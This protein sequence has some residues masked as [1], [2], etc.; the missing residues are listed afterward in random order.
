MLVS[1]IAC[2]L[3]SFISGTSLTQYS[4]REHI[5]Q[6]QLICSPYEKGASMP[7]SEID[8]VL[9]T[10]IRTTA[11]KETESLLQELLIVFAGPIIRSN[12]R[13]HLGFYVSEDGKSANCADALDLNFEIVAKITKRLNLL[14]EH[15]RDG[16]I[17]DYGLYVSRVARNCCADYLREKYPLRHLLNIRIL[18]ILSNSGRYKS[19]RGVNYTKLVEEPLRKR[20]QK[21]AED[22]GEKP[23]N[24]EPPAQDRTPQLSN[25]EIVE[26]VKTLFQQRASNVHKQPGEL[27]SWIIDE[28]FDRYKV[29]LPTATLVSLII[30]IIGFRER[31]IES[32]DTDVPTTAA[33]LQDRAPRADQV[34]ETR[35]SFQF[36][37]SELTKLP[38]LERRIMLLSAVDRE[39]GDLISI[40]LES[41][42]IR[43]SQLLNA[44]EFSR[45]ELLSLWQKIPM[46]VPNLAAC[47]DISKMQVT[48]IRY[49]ARQRLRKRL[50][51]EI[52]K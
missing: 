24:V 46:S 34:I 49:R 40:L 22:P 16:E 28:I 1:V 33:S 6:S 27:L 23:D 17:V 50:Y 25:D 32:I 26:Q 39:G 15:R 7:L 41:G 51:P 12:L 8:A 3:L 37:W 44:L 21:L 13:N 18:Y 30:R 19:V 11:D 52:D 20:L 43:F 47:F 35:E 4:A 42:A 10:Y 9:S 48:K 31:I 2:S 45:D 38:I 29:P 14:K 5:S 36:L